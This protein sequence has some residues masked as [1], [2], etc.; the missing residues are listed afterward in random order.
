MAKKATPQPT[1]EPA[2]FRDSNRHTCI[3][4]GLRDSIVSFIRLDLLEMK[5]ETMGLNR[6]EHEYKPLTDYSVERA[7]RIYLHDKDTSSRNITPEARAHLE[8][9]AGVARNAAPAPTPAPIPQPK[10]E[11]PM[12]TTAPAKKAAKKAAPAK[13]PAAKKTAAPAKKA[14]KATNDGATR[15]RAP[16]FGGDAVITVLAKDNPKR[17]GA[18]ERF[19][20]YKNGMTVD[21]YIAA[22]GKRADVNWDAAQGFIKVK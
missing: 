18:A 14:A 2:V 16:N 20:L 3:R 1:I 8:R 12:S 19:A 15:G 11:P 21:K 4:V 10:K 17:G 13:Q 6:F 22:G 5:I 7:A 9:I